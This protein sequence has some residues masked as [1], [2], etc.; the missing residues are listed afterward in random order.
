M[1]V[2]VADMRERASGVP[3]RVEALGAQVDV[4]WLTT[5]DYVVGP[6]AVVERKTTSDLQASIVD[7]RLWKQMS[8]LRRSSRR[9]YLL[10]E[11]PSL[12]PGPASP[13]A[14]RRLLLGVASMGITVIRTEG[15][16][17]SAEWLFELADRQ[18]QRPLR[19]SLST[20]VWQTPALSPQEQALIAA[21]GVGIGT[22]RA[23]LE[24]YG[25]LEGIAA[26]PL[27]ELTKFPG[28]G[29]QRASAIFSL[30]RNPSPTRLS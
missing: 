1:L 3:E 4:R 27:D 24:R 2:V 28:I 5:G 6:G 20:N 8:R 18:R 17:D 21:P 19:L 7:G 30:M 22:A 9:G 11:S 29:E 14:V 15:P 26:Q 10:V 13:R 12:Y 25:T 16:A 23:L